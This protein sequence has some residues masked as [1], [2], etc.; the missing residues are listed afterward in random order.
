MRNIILAIVTC[1]EKHFTFFRQ[2]GLR[3]CP[4]RLRLPQ[5]ANA[6]DDVLL[7]HRLLREEREA[8]GGQCDR[9]K[10]PLN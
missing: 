7:R 1:N 2:I 6:A 5:E 9:R 4:R 8:H 10:L 3:K